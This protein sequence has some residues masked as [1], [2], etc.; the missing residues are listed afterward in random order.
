MNEILKYDASILKYETE[1]LTYLGD[2]GIPVTGLLGYY[3]FDE[4]FGAT[5]AED[6]WDDNDL[7]SV[8][9]QQAS[10]GKNIRCYYPRAGI[11]SGL[12]TIAYSA[13]PS[14]Y[15][16]GLSDAWTISTWI[17]RVQKGALDDNFLMGKCET[18]YIEGDD[19]YGITLGWYVFLDLNKPAVVI[20]NSTGAIVAVKEIDTVPL[21]AWT[22]L[23]FTYSGSGSSS[24]LNIY[25][26]ADDSSVSK[27]DEPLAPT[28][29]TRSD[30]VFTIGF[31]DIT[32]NYPAETNPLNAY[33]DETAIYNRVISGAEVAFIYNNGIG[34]FLK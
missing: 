17:K 19:K 24:G 34:R 28:G 31:T 12:P 21:S 11:G 29:D 2:N 33:I 14:V 16:F 15:N 10:N 27:Y 9:G 22:H 4:L 20:I 13:D 32:D 8:Y 23:V 30:K 26:N 5:S 3:K 18:S 1:I 25:L 7:V 6:S